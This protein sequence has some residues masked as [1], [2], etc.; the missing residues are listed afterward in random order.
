MKLRRFK[1][2]HFLLSAFQLLRWTCL[3][4][5]RRAFVFAAGENPTGT[6]LKTSFTRG[7]AEKALGQPE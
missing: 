5:K 7:T 1:L 4:T 6:R 3:L 2:R